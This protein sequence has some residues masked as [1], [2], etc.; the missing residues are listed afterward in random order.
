MEEKTISTI[1]EFYQI[2]RG[3]WSNH[4]AYRG[5][6]SS[7]YVLRP[8]FGRKLADPYVTPEGKAYPVAAHEYSALEKFKRR[9]TPFLDRYPSDEWDWLAVAQH[10]GLATRL[11]DWTEN[12]LVAAYFATVGMEPND[13]V[14]YAL[15]TNRMPSAPLNKSP[16]SLD[17]DVIFYPRHSTSRITAQSGLFTAHAQP[18]RPFDG[19]IMERIVISKELRIELR[20]TLNTYGINK[21][22][23][24]PGLDSVAESINRGIGCS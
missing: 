16:F 1:Q 20:I 13:A 17:N 5:E 21:E 23:L 10:H 6:D 24:F 11:L 7:A 2:R 4:F 9:A 14:I 3:H 12:F 15:D 8:K 18:E 22:S 19:P